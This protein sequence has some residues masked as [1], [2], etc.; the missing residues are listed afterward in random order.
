MNCIRISGLEALGCSFKWMRRTGV[1]CCWAGP[2]VHD[3]Q[4]KTTLDGTDEGSESN[5]VNLWTTLKFFLSI[6]EIVQTELSEEVDHQIQV[7]ICY[8]D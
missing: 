8:L 2:Q 6:D 4:K 7:T 3:R 5:F 1:R